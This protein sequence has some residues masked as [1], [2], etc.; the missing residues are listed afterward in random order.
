MVTSEA[1][2]KA[3]QRLATMDIKGNEYVLVNQRIKAF[4]EIWPNGSIQTE[5]ISLDKGVV[6][7]KAVVKD[8]TDRVL[9]TGLAYEKENSSFINKTSFI[10]NCETSAVGRA[11]GMCG[12]GVDVSV[13][14]AEEMQNAIE[15]QDPKPKKKESKNEK[16]EVKLAT[17][18]QIL[19]INELYDAENIDKMCKFYH[20]TSV[21]QIPEVEAGKVIKKKEMILNGTSNSRQQ[22]TNH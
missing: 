21:D 12:L 22:P 17:K 7:M 9:A 20:V 18:E 1:I 3:N 15:N 19:K 16:P 14:S 5:I 10:E 8:D 4:R 2:K 6:L 11:L 13:A